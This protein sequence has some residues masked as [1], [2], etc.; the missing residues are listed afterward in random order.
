MDK[1]Y[2]LINESFDRDW[3]LPAL[4]GVAVKHSKVSDISITFGTQVV[5]G[6]MKDTLMIGL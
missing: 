6:I 5:S 4:P 2:I 3:T 1:N